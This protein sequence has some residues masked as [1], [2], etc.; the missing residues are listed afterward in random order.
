LLVGSN[1]ASSCVPSSLAAGC[2]SD[3]LA[4]SIDGERDLVGGAPKLNSVGA[5]D[6]DAETPSAGFA[7]PNPKPT[8]LPMLPPPAFPNVN[9][10]PFGGEPAPNV[11]NALVGLSVAADAK[12]LVGGV[13]EE[14]LPNRPVVLPVFVSSFPASVLAETLLNR[15]EDPGVKK[16]GVLESVLLPNNE[17]VVPNAD[18]GFMSENVD[19][20]TLDVAKKLGIPELEPNADEED[21]ESSLSLTGTGAAD[22]ANEN[23]LG[24]DE[25]ES[26]GLVP[27]EKADFE[28]S[29]VPKG[30]DV[31]G[32]SS[33]VL[34]PKPKVGVKFVLEGDVEKGKALLGAEL[35]SVPFVGND[36]EPKLPNPEKP[37]GTGNPVA[38][39][40][41]FSGSGGAEADVFWITALDELSRS[42]WTVVRR[43][44]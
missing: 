15:S 12:A 22:R 25:L 35:L 8:G 37:F 27:N 34:A 29:E 40:A 19:D 6:G 3:R 36:E 28:A 7:T 38:E 10:F 30:D 26:S 11:P 13:K 43:F 9:P 1:L 33:L 39:G 23:E 17:V 5:L 42:V 20:A 14:E 4:A 2:D 18:V 41:A 24:L 16:E 31:A 21:F 32:V 44:L